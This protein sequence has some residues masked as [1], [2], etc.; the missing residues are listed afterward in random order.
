MSRFLKEV[1]LFKG[2]RPTSTTFRLRSHFDRLS[3]RYEPLSD[4][5]STS[6]ATRKPSRELQAQ[7]Q[8]S[9]GVPN[10]LDYR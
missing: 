8:M 1:F 10:F 3:D 4:R 9:D 7:R 2:L 6:S 5:T